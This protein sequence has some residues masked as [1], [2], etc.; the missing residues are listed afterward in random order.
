MSVKKVC[1][2]LPEESLEQLSYLSQQVFHSVGNNFSAL[3]Q[4]AIS[5]AYWHEIKFDTK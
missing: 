4:S 5:C 1:I 2:S 3:I